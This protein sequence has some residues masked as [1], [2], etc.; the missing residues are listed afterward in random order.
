MLGRKWQRGDGVIAAR[1]SGRRIAGG[2]SNL[3]EYAV[4]VRTRDGRTFR[5][6]IRE[7]IM[8]SDL[9]SLSVGD[10]VGVKVAGDTEKVRFDMSD[11][12]LSF[13]EC[14]R[15]RDNAFTEALAQTPGSAAAAPVPV[16]FPVPTP[17]P[18]GA[19]GAEPGSIFAVF[20]IEPAELVRAAASAG[21]SARVVPL[22]P[23]SP[24]VQELLAR[25]RQ[26]LADQAAES[27]RDAAP[28]KR[29]RG[30]RTAAGS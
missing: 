25:T 17:V 28:A 12:R 23:R 1:N 10:V 14:Q 20:G 13:K 19:A 11:P 5:A 9:R 21:W 8:S 15:R 29:R 18:G 6:R 22:D 16:P 27:M 3:A 26:T 7:P 4:D 24:Q 2:Y 30:R